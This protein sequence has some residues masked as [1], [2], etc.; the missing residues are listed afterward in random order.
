MSEVSPRLLRSS[1]RMSYD[2]EVDL[3]W[4]APLVDGQ[5]GDDE[6]GQMT[7]HV[8]SPGVRSTG[9]REVL[10]ESRNPSREGAGAWSGARPAPG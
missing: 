8:R 5:R 2:P 4:D 1:A 6:Q 10:R 9:A 7:P 3:D